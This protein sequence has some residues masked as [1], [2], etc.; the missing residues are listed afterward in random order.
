MFGENQLEISGNKKILEAANRF[1]PEVKHPAFLTDVC[2][3]NCLS[4]KYSPL[5]DFPCFSSTIMFIYRRA[6]I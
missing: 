3:S 5:L 1:P 2:P 6:V 4:K